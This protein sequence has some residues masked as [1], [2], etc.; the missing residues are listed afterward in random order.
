VQSAY[1]KLIDGNDQ[2]PPVANQTAPA[3]VPAGG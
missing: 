3:P 2:P 1:V